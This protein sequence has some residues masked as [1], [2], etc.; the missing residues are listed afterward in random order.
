MTEPGGSP[1]DV[2][3]ET[4]RYWIGGWATDPVA[5]RILEALRSRGYAVLSHAQ[6]HML[7]DI[8]DI[9]TEDLTGVICPGCRCKKGATIQSAAPPK[10]NK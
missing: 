7:G 5:D 1:R 4:V 10:E 8:G 2:I 3:A 9:C 6:I